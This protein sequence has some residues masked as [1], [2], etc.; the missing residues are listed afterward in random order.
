M[1]VHPRPRSRSPWVALFSVVALLVWVALPSLCVQAGEPRRTRSTHTTVWSTSSASPSAIRTEIRRETSRGYQVS[2]SVADG[3]EDGPAEVDAYVLLRDHGHWRNGSGSER[4]WEEAKE[5]GDGADGDVFWF[6]RGSDRYLVTDPGMIRQLAELFAPQE[7]LGRRQGELGYHQG[8][9]GRLQ[10]ELGRK[11][12]ELGR[13]QARLGQRQAVLA[14]ERASR[15]RRDL[16]TD[17]LEREL[18][19]VS[20]QQ[21]EVGELQSEMGTQQS[22]LGEKQSALGERQAALGREQ[23]R[24]AKEIARALDARTREAISSR[25]ARRIER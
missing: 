15:D 8:E 20:R 5:A 11:Q 22:A 23:A 24:V 6:R 18:E 25:V 2:S 9:L 3:E 12:G 16:D 21:D 4:D 7:D 14:L 19:T 17:D 10:G 1:T 13:I